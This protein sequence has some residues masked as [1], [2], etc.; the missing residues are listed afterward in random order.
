MVYRN[1]NFDD[2]T[3]LGWC[4]EIT[5]LKTAH[6]FDAVYSARHIHMGQKRVGLLEAVLFTL[7]PEGLATDTEDRGCFHCV[8]ASVS[9]HMFDMLSLDVDQ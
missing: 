1:A 5:R 3:F 9:E 7:F 2:V 6:V 4:Y 8:P